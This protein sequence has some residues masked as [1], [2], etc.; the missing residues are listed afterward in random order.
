MEG[1]RNKIIKNSITIMVV[2]ISININGLMCVN[3]FESLCAS[4]NDMRAD[5][6]LIQETH[7]N[8]EF[9]ERYKHKYEG[10]VY[11]SNYK[12]HSRGCA[13]FIHS[14]YKQHIE[15]VNGDEDGRY[16]QMKIRLNGTV[17]T[18]H[19]LYASNIIKERVIFFDKLKN[20][21]EAGENNIIGG[22]FNTWISKMDISNNMKWLSDSSRAALTE[23]TIEGNLID[24]WRK[25]NCNARVF[26]RHQFVLGELKQSRIDMFLIDTQLNTDVKNVYYKPTKLSDHDYVILNLNIESCDRGPGLWVFNNML[27]Q[28]IEFSNAIN[29]TIEMSFESRYYNDNVLIWWDTLK[30]QMKKLAQIYSK[31][32]NKEQI[33]RYNRTCNKLQRFYTMASIATDDSINNII[34]ELEDQLEDIEY[35]KCKG[36]ILRSKAQWAIES[37]KNT[38]FF[39]RLEKQKQSSKWVHELYD[40]NGDLH[41]DTK[42]LLEIQ[43]KYY[44]ELYA[45]EN[46]DK[47]ATNYLLSHVTKKLELSG[48]EMCDS[49]IILEDILESLKGMSKNKSPGNDGLTAEFYLQFFNKLGPC[50]LRVFN[51][52]EQKKEMSRSM[53]CGIISLIYKKGDKRHLKNWRP[54]SLLNVDYKILAKIFSNRLK[55]VIPYIVNEFQTCSVPGRTIHDNIANIRDVIDIIESEN[56]EG[57]VIKLDQMK[58]FDK[59]SHEYLFSVLEHIGFGEKF[60]MWIRIF[61][62]NIISATKCN[63]HISPYFKVEKSVRQGCPL[64]AM[65]YVICAEPLYQLVST[66]LVDHGINIPLS[67]SKSIMYQ[68]ADD[69]T[70]TVSTLEAVD[71]V[72]DTFALYGRA[73]GAKLN[74]EKS[75]I[76]PLGRDIDLNILPK[77]KLHIVRGV[78]EILGIYLGPDRQKCVTL[79]WETKIK[80]IRSLLGWWRQRTLTLNGK[81]IVIN[82]LIM[83]KLWYLVTVQTVPLYI[84]KEIRSTIQNFMWDGKIPKIAYH[85][86]IQ[87]KSAGGLGILDIIEKRDQFR[88]KYVVKYHDRNYT[89][90]WKHCMKYA[91]SKYANM[92]L[93]NQIFN[94]VIHKKYMT[95]M[96]AYYR[97]VLEAWSKIQDKLITEYDNE[98]IYSQPIFLNKNIKYFNK[99]LYYETFIEADIVKLSDI[100]YEVIPG[101]LPVNAIYE[102]IETKCENVKIMEIER[103]YRILLNSIPLNWKI[104]VTEKS[105]APTTG[106]MLYIEYEDNK[107]EVE[108]ISKLILRQLCHTECKTPKGVLKWNMI[109]PNVIFNTALWKNVFMKGKCPDCIDVDYRIIHRTI[110]SMQKLY[111]M[112]CTDSPICHVC[113]VEN[114]D[115]LHIFINCS[116]L[117]ALHTELIRQIE[118]LFSKADSQVLNQYD[119]NTMLLFGLNN[120]IK[121]VNDYFI[122]ILLSIARLSIYR[123]RFSVMNSKVKVDI[124]RLFRYTLKRNIEY[125]IMSDY[126]PIFVDKIFELNSVMKFENNT[127]IFQ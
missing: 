125:L 78:I 98:Y 14:K 29:R 110:F 18:L 81:A 122:N 97:E 25:R 23:C 86:L 75:E 37:D 84:E 117:K 63:G 91:L 22:D 121:N 42:S 68:H 83:S 30:F 20:K 48:K 50:L 7:W 101:F 57:Y 55:Q 124:V 15:S 66:R 111:N 39:L 59:V 73:S 92:G 88:L 51:S 56:E 85:I 38:S 31:K 69:S 32:R 96:P 104:H 94:M 70:I 115:F 108:N 90:I 6:T 100:T 26:S 54:I 24:I 62:K 119:Y 126:Q 52:I 28:N 80:K 112:G 74:I 64:S 61:Y 72:L 105:K 49:D 36:A 53:K 87:G 4:L 45:Y 8:N 106:E 12:E 3:K 47:D 116:Q 79:N 95:K 77:C 35:E 1:N 17:Y 46:I 67:K 41:K 19:N 109:Y 10:A 33:Q 99:V 103:N 127:I 107:L 123:R 2:I 89:N 5:I 76:L 102:M 16:I 114:E 40:E 113:G 118:N 60:I 13:I 43:H 11:A 9:F 93:C 21:I 82:S 34:R 65:L 120:K 27:L 71:I 44:E 58:A